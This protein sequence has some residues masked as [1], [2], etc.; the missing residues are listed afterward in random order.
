M[1]DEIKF[2]GK[3]Y[4]LDDEVQITSNKEFFLISPLHGIGMEKLV[5][6]KGKIKK[7]RKI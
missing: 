3:T 2:E 4:K 7:N 1:L 5:G 6:Y